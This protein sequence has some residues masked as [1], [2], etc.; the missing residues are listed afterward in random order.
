MADGFDE[1]E[2]GNPPSRKAMADKGGKVVPLP[3]RLNSG[4]IRPR[5]DGF[6]PAK[7]RKFFKALKKCGCIKD[8]CRVAGISKTTVDRWRK[9]DE[10]FDRKVE[11]A[12]AMASEELDM[13][14]WQRA[15]RGCEEQVYRD[16]K[17]VSV[18]V[19]PS[20]AILRLLMQ[21]ANPEKYGR[22][23]H[24]PQPKDKDLLKRLK[25]QARREVSAAYEAG[26]KESLVAHAAELI[27]MVKRRN[28]KQKLA[29]GWTPGPDGKL[30]VPPGWRMV[31]A[32]PLLPPPAS[33]P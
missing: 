16:G 18:R 26:N 13:I 17:L 31:P 22:T 11:A 32:V 3:S 8:A 10:V 5:H 19:K 23:G 25:Q 28:E 6:T 4:A 14:A 29:E 7:Q 21:G 33:G 24:M 15:T 30:V 2:S 1:G 12:L 20:D 27:G 9:K